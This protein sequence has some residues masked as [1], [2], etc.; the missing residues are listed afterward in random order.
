MSASDVSSNAS[1]SAPV[2]QPPDFLL[3]VFEKSDK[4]I[5]FCGTIRPGFV[6]LCAS[7]MQWISEQLIIVLEEFGPENFGAVVSDNGGG[8]ENGRKLTKEK[9]PH[10]AIQRCMMHGFA[11]IMG[12][13]LGCE[14]P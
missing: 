8:C 13:V 9:Y 3:A 6:P 7:T 12:S 4:V 2:G 5:R 10:L 11:L 1:K 14:H